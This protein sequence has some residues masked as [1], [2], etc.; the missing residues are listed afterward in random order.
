MP[1][2]HSRNRHIA[3][4]FAALVALPSTTRAS[5]VSVDISNFA[6]GPSTLTV[7]VGDTVTWTNSDSAPH[8]VTAESGA[9]DSGNVD[10]GETFTFTFIEPGTYTYR[11]DYHSEMEATIVITPAAVTAP[12]AVLGTDQPDTALPSPSTSS[13]IIAPMLI[14][15]GLLALAFGVIPPRSLARQRSLT[16]G[17][18]R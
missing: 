7:A 11:C 3:I 14:G 8:T 13:G 1:A 16:G 6:F 10:P 4:A 2:N 5:E 17:W 15:L 12:T 18:R 9:F